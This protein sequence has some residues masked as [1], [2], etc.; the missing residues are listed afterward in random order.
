MLP[1]MTHGYISRYISVFY[2]NSVGRGEEA[3]GA[4]QKIV[5][6]I[7]TIGRARQTYQ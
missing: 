6:V 1:P 5:Y 4:K 2:V 3:V 7:V